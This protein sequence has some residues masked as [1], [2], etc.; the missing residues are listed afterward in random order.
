MLTVPEMPI[1]VPA[2]TPYG[3]IAIAL[4]LVIGAGLWV[5]RRRRASTV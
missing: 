3:M 4:V 5:W 2:V 1:I